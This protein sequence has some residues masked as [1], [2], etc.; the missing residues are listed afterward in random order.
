[1]CTDM[2]MTG[3]SWCWRKLC[4]RAKRHSG[5]G[6]HPGHLRLPQ[7]SS[8][9]F[10]LNC[11]L[12]LSICSDLAHSVTQSTF[13]APCTP[14]DGGFDSGLQ[15]SKTFSVNITDASTRK[16]LLPSLHYIKS[17][18]PRHSRLLLLQVPRPLWSRN[19]WVSCEVQANELYP[20]QPS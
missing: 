10:T 6:W 3:P 18:D 8:S 4:F 19:G 17:N 20:Y 16:S 2:G 9:R 13:A 12:I 5:T 7:V 1:M 15:M 11:G 14:M